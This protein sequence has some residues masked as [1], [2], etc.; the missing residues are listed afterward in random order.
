[1]KFV[2]ES[3]GLNITGGD[4]RSHGKPVA[5]LPCMSGP[6]KDGV[7]SF[8]MP[9]PAITGQYQAGTEGLYLKKYYVT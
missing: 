3:A 2:R 5:V 9:M 6:D 7:A 1:M 8:I 4:M